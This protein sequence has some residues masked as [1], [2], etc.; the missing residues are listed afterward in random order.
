[1]SAGNSNVLQVCPQREKFFSMKRVLILQHEDDTDAALIGSAIIA[2]G[3]ALITRNPRSDDPIEDVT[4]F[5]AI[6]VLGSVESVNDPEISPWFEAETTLLQ[7]ANSANIPILGICFGAQALAVALGGSVTRAPYGEY[8]WKTIDTT[9][10]DIVPAGPWFQWHVDAIVP[11]P[12]AEVLATSDCCVQA[13]RIGPHLAVQ[14][15]PEVTDQH[16]AEWPRSDPAGL[17]ESG[18]SATDMIEFTRALL[19]SA[20]ERASALW[21]A[22]VQLATTH[23]T[24]TPS[25]KRAI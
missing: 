4:T 16:A 5:D 1:V 23:L 20:A 22:F 7:A 6:V 11:P 17:A 18:Y 8:G 24:D 21:R 19:P 25:T 9:R 14:F 12:D 13:Y 10:P 15:H 3:G 2:T